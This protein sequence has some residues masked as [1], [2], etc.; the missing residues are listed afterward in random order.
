MHTHVC[1]MVGVLTMHHTQPFWQSPSTTPSWSH[2]QAPSN[3]TWVSDTRATNH[4]TPDL[5]NLNHPMDY[6]GSDQVSLGN[7]TGLP[8]T[9]IGHSQLKAFS[10]IFNLRKILHVPSMRTN[11]LSVNKFY[12]DNKCSFYFDATKF[13]IQDLSS[14]RT[15]YKGSSKDGLYP[16]LGLPSSSSSCPVSTCLGNFCAFLGTKGTKSIWHSRLGHP[17]DCVL[18]QSLINY[19]GCVSIMQGFLQIVA[20]IVHRVNFISFLFLL[21]LLLLWHL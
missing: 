17:Q 13:S 18:H 16:I 4:F 6:Q 19:H 21:P 12:R 5:H 3:T 1:G 2:N 7:G 11:L 15:L 8:I 9:H 14:G 10:H 20:I